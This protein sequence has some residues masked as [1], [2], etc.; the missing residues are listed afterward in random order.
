MKKTS[1]TKDKMN[2]KKFLRDIE[3][4][5]AVPLQK[6]YQKW[7]LPEYPFDHQLLSLSSIYRKSRQTYLK[8]G[9]RFQPRVC[10]TMRG[11]ST[12]DLFKNE[13][14]FTP[15]L[16]ELMWFKDYGQYVANATEM[17]EALTSFTEISIFHEQ[18]HRILWQL[19]PP[20]PKDKESFCRYLNFAESLVVTLDLAMA[21]QIGKKL[22]TPLERLKVIYR[23]SGKDNYSEQSKETYRNYLLATLVTTYCAM[24]RIHNDDILNALNYVLPGQTAIN[25]VAYRRGMELSETFT[26]ITNPEWQALYWKSAETKLSH[27][28]KKS[29]QPILNLPKEVLDLDTELDLALKV[30]EFYGI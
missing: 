18:N 28:H 30:F 27:L 10:S 7:V 23:P 9:G 26:Q 16:S 14:D 17:L 12:Q 11:L 6:S 1:P 15:A 4:V 8:I 19:L 5:C 3:D 22:S 2:V 20:A 13:I 21:D 29:K 25:K 24:E